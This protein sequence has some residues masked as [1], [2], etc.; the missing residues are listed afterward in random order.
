[1]RARWVRSHFDEGVAAAEIIYAYVQGRAAELES[2][3]TVPIY[4]VETIDDV[5]TRHDE[6]YH[7]Y[8]RPHIPEL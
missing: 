3:H 6:R 8:L 5:R 7:V 4:M 2:V 1:M